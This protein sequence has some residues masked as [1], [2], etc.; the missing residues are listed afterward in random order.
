[1]ISAVWK[2]RHWFPRK[3]VVGIGLGDDVVLTNL[4]PRQQHRPLDTSTYQC[5]H[6]VHK[7]ILIERHRDMQWSNF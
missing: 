7:N 6:A 3:K 1:M 2:M 4:P 5:R